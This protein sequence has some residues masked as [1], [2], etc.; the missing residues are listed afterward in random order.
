MPDDK[1]REENQDPEVLA[2][3][4]EDD[5]LACTKHDGGCISNALN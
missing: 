4:A 5:D 2:H 3:E 1:N